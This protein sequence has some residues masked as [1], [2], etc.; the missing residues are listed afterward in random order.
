MHKIQTMKNTLRSFIFISVVAFLLFSTGCKK[1]NP[2]IIGKWNFS[3]VSSQTLYR[4]N[5]NGAA[6]SISREISKPLAGSINITQITDT[7]NSPSVS[8]DLNSYSL[9]MEI[10]TDGTYTLTESYTYNSVPTSNSTTGN[11]FYA[12]HGSNDHIRFNDGGS[13][14]LNGA[15]FA[16]SPFGIYTKTYSIKTLTSNQL[17]LGFDD[18][19][20]TSTGTFSTSLSNSASVTFAR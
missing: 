15:T 4:Q 20:T 6:T 8:I 16:N 5:D 19:N 1:S 3:D 13:V 9:V 17:I 14:L 7:S 10:R 11:W 18:S 12:G 2:S